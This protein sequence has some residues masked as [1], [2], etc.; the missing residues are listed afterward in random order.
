[1]DDKGQKDSQDKLRVQGSN[2]SSAQS[3]EE[4]MAKSQQRPEPPPQSAKP[5]LGNMRQHHLKEN[6]GNAAVL[7]NDESVGL[8]RSFKMIPRV[9]Q[10]N[11]E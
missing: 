4:A 8:Y 7:I 3:L 6:F 5:K 1:M 10:A 11:Y 2:S 9:M